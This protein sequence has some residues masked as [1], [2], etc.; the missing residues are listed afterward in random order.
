VAAH[1]AVV[2]VEGGPDGHQQI[3]IKIRKDRTQTVSHGKTPRQEQR[4]HSI[5]AHRC[6]RF[7]SGIIEA[8]GCAEDAARAQGHHDRRDHEGDGLAAAFG[9]RLLR[10]RGQEEARPQSDA[11][12]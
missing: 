3:E 8:V 7:E 6:C 1:D 4:P 10:G 2:D 11:A 12:R 9:P 5:E